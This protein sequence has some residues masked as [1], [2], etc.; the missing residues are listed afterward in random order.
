MQLVGRRSRVA[1]AHIRGVVLVPTIG[2]GIGTRSIGSADIGKIAGGRLGRVAGEMNMD[3]QKRRGRGLMR[4]RT[5]AAG[6]D[7]RH[8]VEI[9]RAEGRTGVGV[10]GRGDAGR[11][12][13]AP[14]AVAI[15]RPVNVVVGRGA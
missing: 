4:Q 2:Q 3:G 9:G 13:R 8:L 15:Q 7:R 14:L 5:F 6:V 11:Q 10:G 1:V 12:R